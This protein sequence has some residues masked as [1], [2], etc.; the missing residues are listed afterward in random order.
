MKVLWGIITEMIVVGRNMGR[1][2]E[3]N[4]ESIWDGA[5]TVY[6]YAPRSQ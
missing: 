2:Q 5:F 4:V 3:S 6:S 1:R